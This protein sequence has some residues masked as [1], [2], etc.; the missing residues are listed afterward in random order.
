MVADND[1]VQTILINCFSRKQKWICPVCNKPALVENL[2]ID[3]FF[4]ELIK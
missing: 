2:M 3:G 4:T 1:S